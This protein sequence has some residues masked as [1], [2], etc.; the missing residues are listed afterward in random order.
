MLLLKDLSRYNYMTKIKVAISICTFF[1]LSFST[2]T[3]S[4]VDWIV[5]VEFPLTYV[6]L[7]A[8]DGSA[9]KADGAPSGFL[10]SAQLAE[11]KLGVVLEN[12]E[13]FLK[14]SG[15]NRISRQLIDLY[16]TVPI[17]S[18]RIRLGMGY[19]YSTVEGTYADDYT[20]SPASQYMIQ[21]GFVFTA[22]IEVHWSYRLIQSQIE[23][24]NSPEL[25]ETGG[26]MTSLGVSVGF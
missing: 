6:F 22:A 18:L 17:S 16:Y 8:D 9:L 25:L 14:K 1:I 23:L 4:A 12:Y 7:E 20:Q 13:I 21:L 26:T 15:E 5:G 24:K 19:G 11:S 10:F 2:S 3:V